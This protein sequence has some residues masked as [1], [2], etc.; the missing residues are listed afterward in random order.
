MTANMCLYS[1]LTLLI[2]ANSLK[3]PLNLAH[4]SDSFQLVVDI[5]NNQFAIKHFISTMLSLLNAKFNFSLR[6]SEIY[7]FHEILQP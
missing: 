7:S 4:L 5:V 6:F 1:M 2:Y 3:E